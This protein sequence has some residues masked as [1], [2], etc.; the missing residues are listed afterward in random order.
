MAAQK[1]GN[2][3][4]SLKH[5]EQADSA[6]SIRQVIVNDCF[7]EDKLASMRLSYENFEPSLNKSVFVASN[8]V[9]IGRLTIGERS[10]VW[11]SSVIRADINAIEIGSDT[12]VQDGCLLHVTNRHPLVI[13][14]RVT[15]G[16][17]AILHGCRIESD[18]LISMG[19]IVL[20]GATVGNGSIVA[21][22]A[23]LAPGT[24]IASNSLVMG[25]PGR[26]VRTITE[27]DRRKIERGWQ[28]YVEYAAKYRS[29]LA[30][31]A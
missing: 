3:F 12:N 10:S 11:F 26:V 30:P 13:G 14:D 20:D 31:E 6:D 1:L 8:A 17:G 18:C 21:A 7:K 2:R 25:I 5:R 29:M 9:L 23:V 28:N 22:G 24:T 27:E 16:H 15:V 19:A 4:A